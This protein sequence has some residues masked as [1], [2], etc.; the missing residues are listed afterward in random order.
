MRDMHNLSVVITGASSGVGRCIAHAFARRGA[1]AALA[2]RNAEAL[3]EVARECRDLGGEAAP[4]PTD[5]TDDGAMRRLAEAAADRFGGIDVWVNNAGVGAI[6]R[7]DEV[8]IEAHRRTIETNLLGYMYGA[9]AVLPHFIRQ[10]HGVLVNNI[11]VGGY[12][13]TAYAAA[14]GA[15]KFG[16]RAFS[17]A[18]RQEVRAW[19]DIHVCAVYPFFMDTP[20]VQHAAN[21]TGREIKPAPPVFA[22]ERTAEAIVRLVRYPRKT[23]LVGTVTKLAV[24]GYQLAPGLYEWGMARMIEAWLGVAKPSADTEGAVFKPMPGTAGVHGDWRW[25]LPRGRSG[26]L[27]ALGLAAGLVGAGLAIAGS[28]RRSGPDDRRRYRQHPSGGGMPG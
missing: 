3:E 23:V 15:S 20:G 24:A 2:A 22:P 18:L 8:P 12:I 16:L 10:R 26:G 17:N 25:D 19:P 6:G 5:V 13:P 28:R 21:Y 9:H 14:Y 7:F 4:I 1:R 11:S 27:M